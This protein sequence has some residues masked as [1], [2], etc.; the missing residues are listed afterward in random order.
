MRSQI[1]AG[2]VAEQSNQQLLEQANLPFVG[3]PAPP[4]GRRWC[5]ARWPTSTTPSRSAEGTSQRASQ[6]GM[7]VVVGTGL[8]GTVVQV[9]AEQAVVKLVTDTLVLGRRHRARHRRAVERPASRAWPPA[10]ATPRTISATVDT[11][12]PVARGDILITRGEPGSLF[13]TGL[14][15]GTVDVGVD[16]TPTSCSRRSSSTCWPTSDD[17]SFVSVVMWPSPVVTRRR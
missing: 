6:E 15:V 11:G 5:R 12:D 9:S 16:A 3:Q 13:P 4:C 2:Q 10:R 17:L 7:P 8:V 14:P 1:A